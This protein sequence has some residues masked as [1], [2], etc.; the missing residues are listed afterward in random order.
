[1]YDGVNYDLI[2]PLHTQTYVIFKLILLKFVEMPISKHANILIIVYIKI[3]F[4][5]ILVH[6]H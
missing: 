5:E 3:F 2:I 6:L 4:E 1:M